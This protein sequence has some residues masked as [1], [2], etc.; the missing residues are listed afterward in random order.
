M[1]HL[2]LPALC[3]SVVLA[4][5]SFRVPMP[6]PSNAGIGRVDEV[7]RVIDGDTIEVMDGVIRV[8]VLGI[9]SPERGECAREESSTWTEEQLPAGTSVRL[10]PDSTQNPHDRHN[11]VLSYVEYQRDG[12]WV[13]LS[14]ESARSGMARSYVY[15]DRPVIR[16]PQIAAAESEARAAGLGVW[17]CPERQIV[18]GPG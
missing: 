11:R 9:D 4:G 17:G 18:G 8:R 1:R 6:D 14:V 15:D 7:S 10:V 3:A 5:C 12:Q 16:H 2:L 13:D